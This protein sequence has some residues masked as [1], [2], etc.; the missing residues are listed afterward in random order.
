MNVDQGVLLLPQYTN[1][2]YTGRKTTD[3]EGS[4]IYDTK[5][6]IFMGLS[7]PETGGTELETYRWW[8]IT[9]CRW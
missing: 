7:Q 2:G 3:N 6:G 4:I 9:R 1:S 5:T 8:W